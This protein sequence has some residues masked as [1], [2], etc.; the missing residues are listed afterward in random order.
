MGIA[1]LS[2]FCEDESDFLHFLF[3]NIIYT[4]IYDIMCAMYAANE[5]IYSSRML[6][7]PLSAMISPNQQAIVR[8]AD[9]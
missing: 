7:N 3:Y 9:S 8:Q 2:H 6:K 5:R 4:Y 1:F